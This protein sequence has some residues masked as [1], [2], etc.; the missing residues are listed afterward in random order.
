MICPVFNTFI[1]LCFVIWYSGLCVDIQKDWSNHKQS[2]K[3][4]GIYI[5][6]IIVNIITLP[7]VLIKVFDYIISAIIKG[8]SNLMEVKIKDCK[9]KTNIILN[10]QNNVKTVPPTNTSAPPPTPKQH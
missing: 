5:G 1:T 10:N 2:K 9:H 6:D 4:Q 8:V 7:L 3:Y